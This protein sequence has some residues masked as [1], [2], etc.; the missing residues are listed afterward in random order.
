MRGD[1]HEAV[2]GRGIAIDGD[3]IERLV[4]Q[5]TCQLLHQGGRH[6]GIGR[7]KT[8]HGGHV[9]ANHAS[10][11]ADPRD[12]DRGAP[13]RHLGAERF[14]HRIGGHDAFGCTAP[15]V[16]P[17]ISNGGWQPG[18]NTVDRQRLHDDARGERQHLCGGDAQLGG[19][20]IAGGAGTLQPI[21]AGTG[22]GVASVDHHGTDALT[23]VQ[24][25]GFTA[26]LHRRCAKT[27]LREHASHGGP[28][29]EQKDRQILALRLAHARFGHTNAHTG[30]W[31]QVGGNRGREIHWHGGHP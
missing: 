1:D 24:R 8:Q 17:R 14:G 28:L 27:V 31:K 11:L 4:G 5:F 30:H 22:I 6:T 19:Q 29:I 26:H 9:R 16:R 18:G 15:M 13:E 25:Q 2:V 10:A 20:C 23:L 12:R 7:Q 3:P 21:L